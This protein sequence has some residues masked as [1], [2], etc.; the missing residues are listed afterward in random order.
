MVQCSGL[1]E[2]MPCARNDHYLPLATHD[3]QRRTVEFD[4]HPVH[5]PDDQQGWRGHLCQRRLAR[6]IGPPAARHH[7][8]DP[9]VARRRAQCR[10]AAGANASAGA[11]IAGRQVCRFRRLAAQSVARRSREAS[12]AMSKTLRLSASSPGDRRSSSNVARPASRSR[13]AT[14]L[15]RGLSRP[16]PLR[17]AKI[18]IPF[19][20]AGMPKRAASGGAPPITNSRTAPA[21]DPALIART[22]RFPARLPDIPDQTG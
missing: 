4:D 1:L 21:N 8:R 2:E 7:C 3:I 5:L 10:T 20:F 18:T 13:W 9:G 6:Q 12:S 11:E 16:L 17:W 14:W 15:L 22:A 19:R